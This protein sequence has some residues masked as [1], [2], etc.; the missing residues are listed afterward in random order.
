MPKSTKRELIAAG[1]IT[2]I[3]AFMDISG[4]P[5][6][7]FFN[8]H[9]LDIEPAYFT[10]MLNFVFAG[11]LCFA[12]RRLLCPHWVLSFNRH[13]IWSGL[14]K[15]GL[16]GLLAL[17]AAL[18]A[19]YLGLKPHLTNTPTLWKVLM[20]GFVYSI[21]VGIIEELYVRGFLLN[22]VEKLF[23]KS[24]N[25]VF[26]AVAISSLVFGLGHIPGTLGMSPF[27]AVSNVIWTVGLGLYFGAVYK[28]TGNLRVPMILHAVINF[29][30]VPFVFSATNAYPDLSLCII[31]PTYLI[32]GAYGAFLIKPKAR[33][34]RK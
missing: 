19:F 6:A 10:L 28:K 17:V 30:G 18:F 1:A 25:A 29:C 5:S 13:G 20:E 11:L 34:T 27:A 8:V 16:A 7:L 26:W 31:L 2:V 33:R 14:R 21:G 23:L 32:L 24:Q 9:V 4:L 15:Y 22:I 3:M 12:L